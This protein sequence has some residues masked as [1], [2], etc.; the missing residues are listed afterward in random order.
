MY[1]FHV[2]EMAAAVQET[3]DESPETRLRIR[4]ALAAY[5]ADKIA[6]VWNVE[7]VRECKPGI[8]DA[9]AV[10][11]LRLVLR[12]NDASRGVTWDDIVA[13]CDGTYPSFCDDD[14]DDDDDEEES[15]MDERPDG[16]ELTVWSKCDP[17]SFDV[18]GVR[19]VRETAK[20]IV[21]EDGVA[22]RKVSGQDRW[23]PT[24]GEAIAHRRRA[25]EERRDAAQA[26][27]DRFNRI[28]P[29]DTA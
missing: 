1:E 17:V 19:V 10:A 14:D 22:L 9:D 29:R 15:E 27:L 4:E 3:L 13:A 11:A 24:A 18:V 28:F 25:L 23:F 6:L 7:D 16:P 2:D 20:S 21:I 12:R 5:W 26:A 8:S